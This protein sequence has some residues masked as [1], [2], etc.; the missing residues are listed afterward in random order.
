MK[1]H[2]WKSGD[3]HRAAYDKEL[4][5]WVSES[6]AVSVDMVDK[7]EALLTSK[8][9]KDRPAQ[10]RQATRTSTGQAQKQDC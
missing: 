8:D 5:L 2:W 1:K 7:L 4:V 10:S 6:D 3:N 9:A